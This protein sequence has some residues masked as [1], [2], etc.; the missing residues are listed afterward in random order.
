M[1]QIKQSS[2]NC[3][4]LLQS[5]ACVSVLI[6]IMFV[7]LFILKTCIHSIILISI[8]WLLIV[9]YYIDP[10]ISKMKIH[11]HDYLEKSAPMLLFFILIGTVIASFILS[12][13]IPTL[14]Y[15][16]LEILQPAYFLPLGLLLCGITSLAI[17]S[18]WGTIGT[19]GIALMGVAN[20]LEIP[21]PIAAGM[22][23][24]GSHF[25]DKLSPI[26]DT[27]VLSSLTAQTDLYKHIKGMAY[28]TIPAFVITMMIFWYIGQH[29]NTNNDDYTLQLVNIQQQIKHHFNIGYLAMLP[30]LVMFGFSMLKKPAE[31]SMLASVIVALLIAIFIQNFSL[32]E[33]LNAL[34]E[35]PNIASQNSKF[36]STLLNRGGIQSMLSSMA[37][38]ILVIT[39]GGLLESYQI[40]T[41]LFTKIIGYLKTTTSLVFA[42][43]F[44]SVLS[45]MLMG[46]AYISIIIVSRTFKK[47]FQ[48]LGLDNCVL[49]KAVDQ[50]ATFSTPL[51][52]WT[53]A[54][55]FTS[56][57]LNMSP[58]EYISWSLF[59][60][61]SPLTFLIFT[62]I[63]FANIKMY[64]LS[65][66]TRV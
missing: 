61:I 23:V 21:L 37:L 20:I 35:G 50:G 58:T 13:A 52:P 22:I 30:M 59:N 12:G 15:Y 32:H 2:N 3:A 66:T 11:I 19:M 38:T 26:S 56:V 33:V 39:L 28:T 10:N 6:L 47:H 31:I 48:K 8:C 34:F 29:Y 27:T 7:G 1:L 14:I 17:G 4:D 43:L 60:W 25:G 54:G 44:T 5:L 45:N 9:G 41:V 18:T 63:N 51:I 55:I 24:S 36:L 46:E 62:A 16:G 57:T 65:N 49:S 42:T 40:V 53:T 64:K